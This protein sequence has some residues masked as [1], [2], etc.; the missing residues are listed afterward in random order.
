[1]PRSQDFPYP[2][3]VA[4][5]PR[6]WGRIAVV[7]FIDVVFEVIDRRSFS[8]L[9]YWIALAVFWSAATQRVLGIPYDI[10]ARARRDAP[11]ARRDLDDYLRIN[12]DRMLWIAE[13]A[14]LWL[15]AGTAAL[16]SVLVILA[17]WYWVEFAQAIFFIVLPATILGVMNLNAARRIRRRAIADADLHRL[18]GRLRVK[19]QLLGAFFILLTAMFGM[20]QNLVIGAI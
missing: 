8:N 6:N 2:W 15:V 19:T 11:G 10:V 14:G 7:S 18:F 17:F 1:M 16:L 3:T 12:V 5:V 4:R 9:W 13:G 20:Y